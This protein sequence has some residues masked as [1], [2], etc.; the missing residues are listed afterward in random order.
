MDNSLVKTDVLIL[1]QGL[2]GSL[3]SYRLSKA[4][5]EHLVVDRGHVRSSSVAAAGIVNPVTGR[6]FVKT[7]HIDE[8]LQGLE[9]YK[10][11]EELLNVT[12]HKELIVYRD[13]TETS[14]LNQWDMR[15][16]DDAYAP[17]MG[18]PKRDLDLGVQVPA[19]VGPTLRA[20]QVNL[21]EFIRAYRILLQENESLIEEEHAVDDAIFEDGFWRIGRFAARRI[22]DCT[23]A[24]A[25]K[26]N[27]W[28]KLPWR[29]TKGEAFRFSLAD[30][31]R[32][33]AI[34]RRHFICP[35]GA[36]DEVWLGGTN[37][38]HYTT[39]FPSE[40]GRARLTEQASAFAIEVPKNAE[41][42]CA[43]RPTVNDRRP[44]VGQHPAKKG[45]WLCNGLGTKG[46]S[47]APYC[48]AQLLKTLMTDEPLDPDIDIAN[49]FAD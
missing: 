26:T 41:A 47:L 5:V 45:L 8:L 7:W 19:I 33:T 40:D 35:I 48:T 38:D 24:E 34:K 25:I 27:T 39:E 3:L 17:F 12:L 18:Q 21:R 37:Q 4:G 44:L 23:G 42:L 15:R 16:T 6:R 14:A 22:V 9:V 49:R 28:G 13:L 1:G 46:T 20:A 32:D 31:P 36:T 43:I 11:L 30:L 10:E 2:T 29:G